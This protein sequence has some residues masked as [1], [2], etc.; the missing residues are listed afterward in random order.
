LPA[1]IPDRITGTVEIVVVLAGAAGAERPALADLVSTWVRAVEIGFFGSGRIRLH[2]VE[3]QAQRVSGRLECERVS[4]TA[5]HALSRMIRHFSAVKGRVQ[6]ADLFHEGQRL[7][8]EGGLTVPALPQSIPFKVEYPEDLKRYVR[9]EIE[10]RAPLA[11]S[12]RD[13]T[14]AGLAIW[15]ML[16][17]ALGDEERWGARVDYSTRLMSPAIVEHQVDGYFASFECLHFIVLLGLRLHQQ[18]IIERI[19]M[20]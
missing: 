13:A 18:L 10:F 7:V 6:S 11:Q 14:F 12:E 2:A 17:A 19:T 9:V 4:Q 5:F 16:V 3:A 20:E 1:S 15:D 8:A